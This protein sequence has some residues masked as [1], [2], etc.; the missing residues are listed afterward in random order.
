MVESLGSQIGL[1]IER[2]R[3]EQELQREKENAEAA[4]AAR[5]RFLAMLSHELRAPLM[6]VV[7]WA[8][9]AAKQSNLSPEIQ[10]GLKMVCRNSELGVR[11][12]EDLLDLSR[13]TRRRLKLHL[14]T[15]DT[16]ELLQS[17]LDIVRSDM[18][19][20]H[21]KLVVSLA[22]SRHELVADA[23]RLQQVFWSVLR[24]ACKF[25][26]ENGTVSVRSYNPNARTITIE[27]SDSGVGIEPQF[28]KRI[29]DPFE[30]GDSRREGLGLG[31]AI[32]KAIVEM[33]RGTIRAHSEGQGKGAT[34]VI[35]LRVRRSSQ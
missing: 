34:F 28:I 2:L 14:G 21:L 8:D 19:D 11:L 13:L 29:F 27:I 20:R 15:A 35:D 12:I 1:F 10:K 33:H 6:P 18:E 7:T 22:A 23:P 24:N 4:N 5:D 31:L 9:A 26:P 3:I 30:Q 17:A 32:S 16:H 25:T